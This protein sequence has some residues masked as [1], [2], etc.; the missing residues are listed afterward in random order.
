VAGV[1]QMGNDLLLHREAGMIGPDDKTHA[2]YSAACADAARRSAINW[3]V[4]G[5]NSRP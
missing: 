5:S 3:R 4:N 2:A 1:A